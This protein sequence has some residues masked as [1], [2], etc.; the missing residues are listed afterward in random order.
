MRWYFAVLCTACGFGLLLLSASMN[1]AR[2]SD[3]QNAVL[4]VAR[5]GAPK[6]EDELQATPLRVRSLPTPAA[7]YS[8]AAIPGGLPWQSETAYR[9]TVRE[10]LVIAKERSGLLQ[11]LALQ[12]GRLP[13]PYAPEALAGAL[14][15][16]TDR[17]EVDG[18]PLD[19]VG[20][21]APSETLFATSYITRA[22]AFPAQE[23]D[24]ERPEIHTAYLLRGVHNAPTALERKR[25][26]EA[27]PR[28]QYAA[29]TRS[30]R[31]SAL[32]FWLYVAGTLLLLAGATMLAWRAICALAKR[33]EG[34]IGGHALGQVARRPW[35]FFGLHGLAFG[36][37]LLF[38][39]AA[40]A[41]P[42]VQQLLL[43][44]VRANVEQGGG[45]LA[46]AAEAYVARSIPL[47]AL[48]TLLVNLGVG[49]LVSITLPSLVIPGVGVLM[50]AF[51]FGVWGLLLSP[52]TLDLSR[53]MTWHMITLFLEGEGYILAAFFGLLVPIYLFSPGKQGRAWQRYVRA[54]GLNVKGTVAVAVVLTVAAVYEAVEVIA[55]L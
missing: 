23:V 37:Y 47:A 12:S 4:L 25:L 14:A 41:A 2:L 26:A 8:S 28:A 29:V 10:Q 22:D 38:A 40:W 9:L 51:R 45:P 55:Q 16:S 35:L 11:E 52:T 48:R 21:L 3:T 19:I 43:T 15:S 34:G 50:L 32:G 54:V 27:F 36:L 20:V 30:P 31:A 33:W 18:R 44:A 49:S 1:A 42:E 17:L 53:L 7:P 6:P 39:L 5:P 24:P 13:R 46:F